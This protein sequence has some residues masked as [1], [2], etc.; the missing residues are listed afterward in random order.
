MSV[1]TGSSA[2]NTDP[3]GRASTV[4]SWPSRIARASSMPANTAHGHPSGSDVARISAATTG[5]SPCDSSAA[6]PRRKYTSVTLPA[7]ISSGEATKKRGSRSELVI[8]L[9]LELLDELCEFLGQGAGGLLRAGLRPHPH[10]R[11]LRM[12]HHEGP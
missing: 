10:H 6:F 4:T 5:F 1:S 8:G 2:P 12:G 7:R 3:S 11:L 9:A